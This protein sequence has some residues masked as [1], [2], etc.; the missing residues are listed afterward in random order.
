MILLIAS[1]YVNNELDKSN[2]WFQFAFP[3]VCACRTIW[4]IVIILVYKTPWDHFDL[5]FSFF[6]LLQTCHSII[7]TPI[8]VPV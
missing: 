7:D 8:A 5:F 3:Q 2:M 4:W 1:G 6:L